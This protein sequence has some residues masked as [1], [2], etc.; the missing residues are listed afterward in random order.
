M[1]AQVYKIHSDFYYVKPLKNEGE[2]IECKLREI[3]KKQKI[4][5]KV[6]DFVEV[7][8]GAIYEL[9]KRKNTIVRPSVSNLD[10]VVV[11]SSLLEP[12]VDFIQLNRYLT[13]LKYNKIDSLLCFNKDDLMNEEELKEKEAEIRKIYEPL[14]YKIVFT[15]ALYNDG[16]KEFYNFIKNKPLLF[17]VYQE[18]GKVPF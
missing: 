14:G 1:K 17:Q 3:L 5:I 12:T 2:L 8:N 7:E 15:S 13:F 6:G 18:L 9:L 4:K 10:L 11:V 16:M